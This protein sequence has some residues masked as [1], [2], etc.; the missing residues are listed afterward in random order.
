MCGSNLSVKLERGLS[1]PLEG[2]MHRAFFLNFVIKINI[3]TNTI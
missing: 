2:E 1:P 3:Q